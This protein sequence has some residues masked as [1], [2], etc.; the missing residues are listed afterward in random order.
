M[1]KCRIMQT[2]P[3]DATLPKYSFSEAKDLGKNQMGSPPTEVPNA[4]EIS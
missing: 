4:G 1:A 3:H 2:M